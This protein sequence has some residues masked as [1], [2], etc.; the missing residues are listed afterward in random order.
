MPR[1][2]KLTSVIGGRTVQ[3]ATAEPG[4]L[5]IRFDDQSTMNVKRAGVA[6]ISPGGRIKAIQEDGAEF[7]LQ[8]EDGSTLTLQL[9]D[10]GSSV[11]VRDNDNRVEYLGWP[12]TPAR[13]RRSDEDP[14]SRGRGA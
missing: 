12:I 9:A 4:K 14:L 6:N 3:V 1:N 10:P 5:S 8:F 7:N 11:A 13:I 2:H